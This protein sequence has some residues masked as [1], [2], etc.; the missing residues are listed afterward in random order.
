MAFAELAA[1]SHYSFLEGSASPRALV[2]IAA[3]LDIEA[4]G[5]CDRNGLYGAV[6]FMEAAQ[7]AGIRAVIGAELDLDG[8]DRLRLLARHRGGYRQLSRAISAAQL[9]GV[10]GQPR[11]RLGGLDRADGGQTPAL[12][13]PRRRKPTLPPPE[14]PAARRPTAG[15]FPQGW[16][17]LPS[18]TP[19]AEGE[20]ATVDPA[21]LDGCTV[22]AGGPESAIATALV[23]GDRRGAIRRAEQLRDL[24]GRDRVVLALS[25]H[26]HPG[27]SWLAAE[28]SLL[29]RRT[30]LPLLATGLPVHAN[31]DDK[32]LLDVLTAIRHRT[33]LDAAAAHGLLLPNAEHRLRSQAELRALLPDNPEAFDLAIHLASQCDLVLDFTESRFP[34]FPVAEGETPFSVLYRLCQESVLRRYAPMTRA[35]AARLQ[36]ELEVIEKTNLAEFFLITWDIMRFAREHNI[37]GQGRGSAAD[38]IVAYLLG[39]TRVDPVEHDLLFERFLH[40]DHQG[41]PDI[42]IDFS[43]DHREEVLQYVYD[44]YGA[45]RTGMVANIITYRPRMAMRQVGAAMGFPEPLIDRLAKAV[46]GWHFEWGTGSPLAH[47]PVG[48]VSSGDM[49]S[50]APTDSLPWNQFYEVLRQIEGTPRHLGIHVG[51]MLVTGEP[52]V[53]VAPVERATMPGRVVVQFNKDDVEDLGLIKMDLL[54]LRTLSAIAECLDLIEQSTG[55]RPD[56][57]SLPLDDPAVYASIQ[58]VDTIGLFQIES[59]AQQQSLWQ[60]QPRVFNDLIVQVAIIRPGPIQGDAVNPYLRRRQ[61]LEPVTFLHP[62]LEPILSETMGVI[63]YQEQILRIVMDVAGY[64]AGQADRFRR[65]MNRHRSRIEMDELRDEFVSRCMEV[66]GMPVEV[67]EQIF[68]G[69]AGFAQFGFCKSHA[70]AFARTAYET[71][72]LRLHHPAEYVCALLNAQPMGFYHPSV[73]VE[74]AKRHGVRFLPVDVVRSRARCTIE[75]I[76]SDESGIGTGGRGRDTGFEQAS[77]AQRRSR[78]ATGEP[79]V[80]SP[81]AELAGAPPPSPRPNRPAVRLGFN[82]MKAVGPA[83]RAA[84]EAAALAGATSLRDFWRHTL[85]PRRAMENLVL[86]G[87]FDVAEQGRQRRQLLWDLKQVEESL[88]PRGPSRRAAQT[89]DGLAGRRPPRGRGALAGSRLGDEAPTIRRFEADPLP[90]LLE[91]PAAAPSLPEMDERARVLTEYA[92]SEVSTG[93]HLLSFIRAQLASLGCRPLAT[94]RDLADGSHVRVAGLVIARQAPA[95]ASGFRFFTLA[96]EDAHLDLIIRPAVVTRTRQVANHNPLLMVEGRLQNERG[97]V[98]LVV[99]TVVALTG[100]GLP[101]DAG[102]AAPTAAPSSHDFH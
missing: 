32:P 2:A 46:D 77:P 34:G 47:P 52:L 17:G 21:D 63:L 13:P 61:G 96:D 48:G 10:K 15:P 69:A 24:F 99:E 28:T 1:R 78:L 38:S 67:A 51:G 71:A 40:E 97:R 80:P 86:A 6:S 23:R 82:Y 98:N 53:D 41:T 59:R 7:T 20:P 87:A 79:F 89:R 33:T 57:D 31:H 4:L 11:L 18:I 72:W 26:R 19:L 25:H 88:P 35:V 73:L 92:L 54:G 102:T 30:G 76:E 62:S 60:S 58:A 91:V 84:C 75:S 70:A 9:A 37:P 16:P 50:P 22:I 93:R 85:L 83:A 44:K 81:A 101:V 49:K 8:G 65:A 100:D 66:S 90:P 95:S 43:T 56:L 29:G 45:E 36:R 3:S 42:D 27:D 94:I 64:T 55:A 5:L 68:K 39:I 74:D 12:A 14:R